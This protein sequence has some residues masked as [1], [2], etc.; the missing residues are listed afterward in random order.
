MANPVVELEAVRKSF[1]MPDGERANVL[2]I[3]SFA[4]AEG[5]QCALEG[6]SGSG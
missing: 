1:V 2:D 3:P 5:E 4:L 6:T